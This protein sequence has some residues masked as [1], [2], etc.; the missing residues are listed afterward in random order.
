MTLGKKHPWALGQPAR[1]VWA[2]AWNDLGPRVDE[3][4]R[5]GRATYDE[6]L[7]L[8]LERSGY[9]E[10]TYHTFSYSPLRDDEGKASGLFC[11][12]VEDTARYIA[13]RRVKV[14]R[15]VATEVANTRTVEGAFEG[16]R[17]CLDANPHDLPFTL[18]Y[19][20]EPDGQRARLVCSTGFPPDEQ[21]AAPP[22][23]ELGRD[24]SA[25]PLG[26]VVSN[27]ETF[28]LEGLAE[29]FGDLP[30]GAW[31]RA[32]RCAVLV[33]IA[34]HGRVQAAG[35]M[36][37]GAN[38]YRPLD[39][40]YLGFINL[41]TRQIAAGLA[42]VRA[43]EDE[44]KRA[45][46][47][48]EIDRA[49]TT[50]F[51]NVSHEFRTPL[52]LILSPLEEMLVSNSRSPLVAVEREDLESIH[53]NGLRLLKLVNSLLD[54][55]RIEAGRVQ[56][57]YE[58]IDLSSYSLELASSFRSAM[59]RAG[60]KF[61]ISCQPLPEPVYVDREMWEKIVLNLLSNAFKYTLEGTVSVSV[62]ASPDGKAAEMIIRD[63]GIG[64]PQHEV[65]RL[66]ER[67]HRIEGQVGRTQEGTGIGLALVQELVR[68]HGGNV[69]VES[70]VGRGS[71]FT[72]A[73]PFGNKQL[74]AEG[75]DQR[76]LLPTQ[77][78]AQVFV[79]EALRWLGGNRQAELAVDE[80]ATTLPLGASRQ[81]QKPL[82]I[83]ADDNADMRKYITRLLSTRFEVHAVADGLQLLQLARRKKPEAILSDIMM[84]GLDGLK[85]LRELRADPELR[86]IPVIM[87]SARAGEESRI[88]GLEAGADDYL[89]KPFSGRELIARVE[90]VVKMTVLRRENEEVLRQAHRELRS[91][92]SELERFNRAAVG[93][94]LRLIE[95]KTEIAELRARLDEPDQCPPVPT[96]D[97]RSDQEERLP[98]FEAA[99]PLELILRTDELLRRPSRAPDHET[100]NRALASLVSSLAESPRTILQVLVDKVLE[101][102]GTDSAGLSLLTKNG[103]RFYW[104]AI[105]GQWSLHLGGGTPREFGPCGD[106]LNCNTPLLFTRWERRYPYLAEVTPLAEEGLLVPF[107]IGAKAVGTI[108]AIAHDPQRKF[109][110]EDLRLLESIGR[111]ASAAYQVVEYQGAV[112]QRRA[113]L[114]LLE[115]TMQARLSAEESNRK[116]HNEIG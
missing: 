82:V 91:R 104:A 5:R 73:I 46:A 11:V 29:R 8:L 79:E 53:R 39:D 33:P 25:W 63:T 112:E 21:T 116:L 51:S 54:F 107:H 40:T 60:L 27:A 83:V 67:F 12:V 50:F 49:K 96:G 16:T 47:L 45:E 69:R 15:E 75:V 38:P 17:K 87:L 36:V 89:V 115:D 106:V 70:V 102:L 86:G 4:I 14:L 20:T 68:L 92:A 88:E 48:A 52:T 81:E 77:L 10:E 90:S 93:R 105:A 1:E 6:N 13:E 55:A 58:A 18:I 110:A 43:Y 71:A 114:N 2:E 103:E 65:P 35:V 97:D 76:K 23:I 64:I 59:E 84:P 62:S 42:D 100:E 28:V 72:V 109:D 78:R 31:K 95:L 32:P 66:F 44:R 61:E 30:R 101:V 19:L 37:V 26:R 9:P 111:F 41:L 22:I 108:W 7:L 113:A 24:D 94:E 74:P 80:E 57:A 99:A 3:V 34:Q 56:A 98:P 85:L